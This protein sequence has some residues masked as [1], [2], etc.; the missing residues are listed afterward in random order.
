MSAPVSSTATWVPA[1][2]YPA[3]QAAGAPI[4]GTLTSRDALTVPSSQ[5]LSSPRSSFPD[6]PSTADQNVS[7]PDLVTVTPA[8]SML[9]SATDGSLAGSAAVRDSTADR[10]C[11]A[12]YVTITGS[13]AVCSSARP[14][15]TSLV[16]LNSSASTE[17]ARRYGATRSGTTYVSPCCV[18]AWTAPPS[19]LSTATEVFPPTTLTCTTSPVISV[20][21]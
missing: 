14:C 18:Y 17:P 13:S 5:I 15:S 20:T 7:A 2:S 3:C 4:C 11:A 1:P 8:P 9:G 6:A 19:A 10:D 12:S 21:W 16:T